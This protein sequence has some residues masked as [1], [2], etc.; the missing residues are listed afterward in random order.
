[1]AS[2]K[3]TQ[4]A[5]ETNEHRQ[6]LV[7]VRYKPGNLEGLGKADSLMGGIA[8]TV[9]D[10]TSTIDTI[11]SYIPGTI[12]EDPAK[13][14]KS[15]KEYNYF[16]TYGKNWDKTFSKIE[17]L[18]QEKM[19][20]A[21]VGVSDD[22]AGRDRNSAFEGSLRLGLKQLLDAR[23]RRRFLTVGHGLCDCYHGAAES[24]HDQSG[25]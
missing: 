14:V 21:R 17:T 9:N 20:P 11:A 8:G 15:E 12:K 22:P 13:P 16:E 23:N 10:V 25:S 24:S 19:N 3:D 2:E 7:L 1:M 5:F 6:V 4:S 18:L